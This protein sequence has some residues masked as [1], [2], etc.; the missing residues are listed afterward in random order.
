MPKFMK[1]V[2]NFLNNSPFK[3]YNKPAPAKFNASLKK[4]S[5]NGKLNGSPKFKAAVDASSALKMY[6]NTPLRG[7]QVP[8]KQEK[9]VNKN[10]TDKTYNQAYKEMTEEK[11]KTFKGKGDFVKKAEDWWAKQDAK[12]PTTGESV[13]LNPVTV[14]A[15]R[16]KSSKSITSEIKQPA[17]R[18]IK[19][20]TKEE[21]A[22]N[23]KIAKNKKIAAKA[24]AAMDKKKAAADGQKQNMKDKNKLK[25][26]IKTLRK[27]DKKKD[28]KKTYN[29]AASKEAGKKISNQE[30]LKEK[31]QAKRKK[32]KAIRKYKKD[33]NNMK[34]AK[35][36]KEKKSKVNARTPSGNSGEAF[37]GSPAKMY[38]K[39]PT[40]MYTSNAQRKAVHA[41]K[42]D[43]KKN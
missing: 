19:K 41:S 35:V 7:M 36:K 11:R 14:T 9:K 15:D 23:A 4:A 18:E 29:T 16:I 12:K 43:K 32:G 33:P 42:A 5:A 27:S 24:K 39:S 28:R 20:V 8:K 6:K 37:V 34:V 40:K 31:R 21:L 2:R 26:E 17:T 3:M 30:L 1:Q 38:K 22:A 13:V 25:A 10:R